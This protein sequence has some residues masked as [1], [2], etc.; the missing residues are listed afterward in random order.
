MVN[1]LLITDRISDLLTLI[2]TYDHYIGTHPVTGRLVS[3]FDLVTDELD[4]D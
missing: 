3:F 2:I 1:Y 4:H